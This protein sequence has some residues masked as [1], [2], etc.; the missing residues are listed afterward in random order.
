MSRYGELDRVPFW[1]NATAHALEHRSF[2]PWHRQPGQQGCSLPP[3]AVPKADII[4]YPGNGNQVKTTPAGVGAVQAISA[5]PDQS[6]ASKHPDTTE[7]GCA[8][9]TADSISR[10]R[11]Q[12]ASAPESSHQVHHATGLMVPLSAVRCL[13][14][15][16]LPAADG[17]LQPS[18]RQHCCTTLALRNITDDPKADARGCAAQAVAMLVGLDAVPTGKGWRYMHKQSGYAFTLASVAPSPES[19]QVS[20]EVEYEPVELGHANE[21]HDPRRR[22]RICVQGTCLHMA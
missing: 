1:L 7:L 11:T 5:R 19:S 20:Q 6:S 8:P 16:H 14:C 4:M 22:Q 18:T 13:M 3:A 10:L 15:Q 12:A 9:R 2:C 17:E 21:V